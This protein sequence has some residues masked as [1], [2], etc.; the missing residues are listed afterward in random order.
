MKNQ[1]SNS[2]AVIALSSVRTAEGEEWVPWPGEPI[3]SPPP[4]CLGL[5]GGGEN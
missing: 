1:E 3:P 5:V 4:H 2:A